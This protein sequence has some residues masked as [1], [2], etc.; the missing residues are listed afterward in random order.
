MDLKIKT[1][2]ANALRIFL[3]LSLI[4][5]CFG[6]ADGTG[7]GGSAQNSSQTG[8]GGGGG[9]PSTGITNITSSSLTITGQ[10]THVIN[11]EGGGGSSAAAVT[12]ASNLFLAGSTN[13]FLGPVSATNLTV[14]LVFN[15]LGTNIFNFINNDWTAKYANGQV[16]LNL[17]NSGSGGFDINNNGGTL[18]GRI[19]RGDT[20]FRDNSGGMSVYVESRTL[21]YGNNNVSAF[22]NASAPGFNINGTFTN[23]GSTVILTNLNVNG[24]L[25]VP[26][27]TG[28][29]SLGFSGGSTI[30]NVISGSSSLAFTTTTL[31]FGQCQ[32]NTFTLTG[33][34]AG[35]PIE[36]GF[37]GD[38]PVD[39]DWV[40]SATSAN[41][42]SVIRI[43]L[44]NPVVTYTATFKAKAVKP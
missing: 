28:V 44:V 14:G 42:I 18:V 30:T 8:G 13:T 34:A 43:A 3:S 38:M 26:T 9:F 5:S 32:T 27:I 29:T 11:I 37:P 25:N 41:T 35:D 17:V 4:S 20:Q 31:N 22:W 15:S 16:A 33:I 24:T 6:Q 1:L 10:G 7:N 12:N 21:N 39:S 23:F 40:M 2:K 19:G 36:N